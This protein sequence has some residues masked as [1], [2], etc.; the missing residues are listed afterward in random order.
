MKA[1]NLWTRNAL[2]TRREL[3]IP[4]DID[5]FYSHLSKKK[6]DATNR[7]KEKGD[8]MQRFC[9]VAQCERSVAMFYLEAFNYSFDRALD[10]YQIDLEYQKTNPDDDTTTVP[11]LIEKEDGINALSKVSKKQ[12]E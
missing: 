8:L 12:K 1:N 10:K 11:L 9:E 4:I 7:N 5:T 3:I 6:Q 2:H